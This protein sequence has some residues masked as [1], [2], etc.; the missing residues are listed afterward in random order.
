MHRKVEV[1]LICLAILLGLATSIG[2]W[3]AVLNA[4]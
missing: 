3:L 4:A 2:I 1:L